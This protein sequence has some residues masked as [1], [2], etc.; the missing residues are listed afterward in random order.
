MRSPPATSAGKKEFL[1]GGAGL[2]GHFISPLSDLSVF[3][4]LLEQ[5]SGPNRPE[6][7]GPCFFGV[8]VK[9]KEDVR[10]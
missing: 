8:V 7:A 3:I 9:K 6:N 1:L 10:T 5:G 2:H 4:T